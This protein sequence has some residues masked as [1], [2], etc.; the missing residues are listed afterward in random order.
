MG[1]IQ[2]GISKNSLS[3]EKCDVKNRSI[4]VNKLENKHFEC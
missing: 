4:E 2:N 3:L 1:G